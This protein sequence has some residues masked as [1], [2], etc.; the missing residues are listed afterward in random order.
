MFIFLYPLLPVLRP[1]TSH[2]FSLYAGFRLYNIDFYLILIFILLLFFLCYLV[3][4]C[5]GATL[6][7]ALTS[8]TN[9][10]I[11]RWGLFPSINKFFEENNLSLA[12]VIVTMFEFDQFHHICGC[13]FGFG[14]SEGWQKI[15][16]FIYLLSILFGGDIFIE[17]G[18]AF[19]FDPDWFRLKSWL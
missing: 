16:C 4:Y 17:F 6:I 2:K 3:L 10:G 12:I 5:V 19:T 15:E 13:G 18:M 9:F 1:I 7:L 11:K 8:T 14:L